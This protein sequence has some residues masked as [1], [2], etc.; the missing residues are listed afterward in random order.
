MLPWKWKAL[1]CVPLFA[2]PWTV[3][4]QAPLSMEF[5][6]P[7]YWS[8][9]F[10][11]G[12]FPTQGLNPGPLHCRRILFQLS[13]QRS[14]RILE[15]VVHPFSRGL[16]NAPPALGQDL[17]QGLVHCRHFPWSWENFPWNET[18][19]G[20]SL[21]WCKEYEQEREIDLKSNSAPADKFCM[22]LSKFLIYFF[23][24]L[25]FLFYIG[26]TSYFLFLPQPSPPEN[27][28]K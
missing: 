17:N 9:S 24:N 7:Q 5:S 18:F 20:G 3:D 25:N 26:V 8:P 1:S 15:W 16:E 11:Q 12:I 28:Q 2:T 21:L 4:H 13:H 14:P 23:W 19:L 27:R 6:R 10:L 22:T